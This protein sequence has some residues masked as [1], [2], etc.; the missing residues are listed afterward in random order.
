[1]SVTGSPEVPAAPTFWRKARMVAKVVELRLRFIALMA[2]TGLVFAY[3][4]TIW[5]QIDKWRR[6]A[7]EAES[8]SAAA[9]LE[10]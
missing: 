1:M 7:V 6:P 3:W 9:G 8:V 4:D 10:F 2:I 5:N